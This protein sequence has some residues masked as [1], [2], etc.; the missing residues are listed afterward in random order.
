MMKLNYIG[1]RYNKNNSDGV[2]FEPWYVEV[3]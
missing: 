1:M 2:R 3:I